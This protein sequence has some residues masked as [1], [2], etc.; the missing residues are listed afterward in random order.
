MHCQ[1]N[2]LVVNESSREV[3]VVLEKY[4]SHNIPKLWKLPGGL[5][6]QGEEFG[7]AAEREVFEETGVKSKF[8]NIIGFRHQNELSFRKSDI[9]I[10]CLMKAKTTGIHIDKNELADAC[11]MPIKEFVN[12]T[13]HPMNK[14]VFNIFEDNEKDGYNTVMEEMELQFLKT[15]KP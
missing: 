15:R 12:T 5:V 9:Y 13:E 6:N 14:I 11:W 8:R 10:Y 3:L 2:L 7:D 4:N 1:E